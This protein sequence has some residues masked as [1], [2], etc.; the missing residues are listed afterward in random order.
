MVH[1]GVHWIAFAIAVFLLLL[2][3]STRPQEIL[4]VISACLLGL[5]LEYAQHVM[6]G[7]PVEW[8]DV[9]NDWLAV[10]LAFALYRLGGFYSGSPVAR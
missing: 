10:L 1:L 4:A 9:R 6:Y 2:A 3:S 8:H 7:F 5:S